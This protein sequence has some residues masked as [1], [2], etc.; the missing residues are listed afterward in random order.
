M[1]IKPWLS[2][3]RMFSLVSLIRR[4]GDYSE[5]ENWRFIVIAM[6][7][8]NKTPD[9]ASAQDKIHLSPKFPPRQ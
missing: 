6:N 1:V 7:A 5:H 9:H 4:P 3:C 2:E 8:M